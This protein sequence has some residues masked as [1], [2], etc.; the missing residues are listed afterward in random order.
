MELPP[1]VTVPICI[2][3]GSLYHFQI[4]LINGDGT[5]YKGDRFFIVLNTDPKRDEILIFTT[6]TSRIKNQ[7]R[8][9]Q[10]IGEDPSTLVLITPSDFPNLS[11]ESVVNCNNT[12]EISK[13]VLIKKI[14]EG[15]KVYYHKLPKSIVNAL[16]Q[17]VL[18]SKQVPQERKKKLV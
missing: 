7:Q 15:G 1:E 8:Y 14:K 10:N 5:K 6:I 2:E 3:R 4:E 12:H 11:M 16:I 9:I 18:V 17:G 13:D